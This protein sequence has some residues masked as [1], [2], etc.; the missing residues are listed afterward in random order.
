M[1]E[2]TIEALQRQNS[3]LVEILNSAANMV[4]GTMGI[5]YSGFDDLPGEVRALRLEANGASMEVIKS[6][7][8]MNELSILLY[9]YTGAGYEQIKGEIQRLKGLGNSCDRAYLYGNE[10]GECE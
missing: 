6:I 10:G 7:Q 4:N 1:A 9:G 3:M 2:N 5:G 8:K